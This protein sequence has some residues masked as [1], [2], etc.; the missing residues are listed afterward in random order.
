MAA[1]TAQTREA[2]KVRDRYRCAACGSF[3]ALTFQHRRRVGMGGSKNLPTPIDGLTLCATCNAGCEAAMQA[4]AL[5]YGWKVRAW[6]T[7]PELV[8]VYYPL[9]M[10]WFRLEGVL[11]FR[12]SYD[13]ALEMGCR[14]YGPEW[15]AWHEAVR[16]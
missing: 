15:L 11:R 2:V 6:V 9:E 5:R 14:V 7:N 10:A 13:V 4:Q 8:P 16:V 12:I 3:L 1:P